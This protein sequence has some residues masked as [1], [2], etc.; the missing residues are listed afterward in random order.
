MG[1][2]HKLS[3]TVG[4]S[5]N[6]PHAEVHSIVLPHVLRY[7][8]PV[9]SDAIAKLARALGVEDAAEGIAELRAQLKVPSA[10]RDIGMQESDL[11]RAAK[12]ATDAPYPNPRLYDTAQVR[13]LLDDAY[14]GQLD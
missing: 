8:A 9:V 1:L 11:D 4:G 14:R 12:L 13:R 3:H 5:F 6:L 2:H 10:L 7:N